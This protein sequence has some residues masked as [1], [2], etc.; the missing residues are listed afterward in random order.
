MT[1][2]KIH[3]GEIS[4]EAE[5]D[6]GETGRMIGQALPIKSR[7]NTWGDEIYFSIPLE[8]EEAAGAR[9][10]MQVG[11]LGYWPV[12]N[13][14]CIFFGPTPA[15]TSREPRAA[16]PVNPCGHVL[17][18]LEALRRVAQGDPVRITAVA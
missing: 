18:K 16:S 9:V 13:A 15:S 10:E 3:A 17:G 6:D 4:V 5:L 1:I 14:L 11:E 7:A 2:V 12:G 8:L